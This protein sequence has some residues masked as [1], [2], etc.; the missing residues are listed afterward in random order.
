MKIYVDLESGTWGVASNLVVV[1]VP[2]TDIFDSMS[3]SEIIEYAME[4][5]CYLLGSDKF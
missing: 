5:P 4:A 3:D 1:E 2:D